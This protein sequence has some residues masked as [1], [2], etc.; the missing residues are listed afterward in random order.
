[1]AF[2]FHRLYDRHSR[3]GALAARTTCLYPPEQRVPSS[4]ELAVLTGARLSGICTVCGERGQF[5]QFTDNMRESG[6]CPH[7]RSSNRI[8][9]MA[10]M[11]RRELGL[12]MT[13]R[14]MVPG[15]V[16]VYNTEANG[17]LHASLKSHPH[18]EC[19]EYWG[20]RSEYGSTVDGV[21]NEDLQALSFG[22]M[23]FDV[24]LSSDVLEHMPH[25]YQAHREI[26]RVLKPGG[27]HI[28]T[29]P[30]GESTLR[31]DVRATLVDGEIV[32]NAPALYHG[33]PVRPDEGILVWNIFGV[34]MLVRLAEA[35][36]K[37]E[38]WRL[39]EPQYGIIGPGAIVFIA[40]KPPSS[41]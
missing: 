1:M 25:P 32:Y 19:S 23:S 4:H 27:R 30:Y 34:E 15:D 12:P 38:L 5:L 22:D 36:F 26:F 18:Y 8:R 17:A 20:D 35:G 9:Q 2:A 24:V 41:S 37:T 28:F 39:H 6:H 40:R 33:D 11:L 16:A 13:G 3:R 31:D 14:L 7:C 10:W 29:V 21:R